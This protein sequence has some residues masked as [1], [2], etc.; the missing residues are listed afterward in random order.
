MGSRDN[1]AVPRLPR[2]WSCAACLPLLTALLGCGS[3][4]PLAPWRPPRRLIALA[5]SVTE[6]VYALGAEARLVGVC[7]Q[8]DFP[9]AATRLPRVGGYLVPSVEAVLAAE[10]DL[11]VVVPSPGNREAV[12]AIER[13]GVRVLVVQDR[14]LADLWVS[15]RAVAGALGLAAAG[16]QLVG[17]V[18]RRLEAVRARV[19]D[20]P[21]RRVLLVVGHSPLVVAG[22]GTL[23][24]ELMTVAGGVNV[25]ADAG[26]SW[27]QI[28][29]ELVVARGPEVIIDAAMGTEE[30]GR[31]LFAGLVTVPAVRAG[32]VITF[33]A[34]TLYR[35][36]P[37]VPEAAAALAAVIHPE[38]AS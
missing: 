33:R 23:Q 24:D 12:R 19:A 9:E 20:L 37:R 7:A 2:P 28:S 30:G 27:P 6:I 31:E 26:Q 15:M 17:D 5:P 35:A 14:T 4:A 38:A 25:A 16:E 21:R 29:L 11:V 1:G 36:G 3:T 22:G 34:D 10:P 13:A 8:C 32:R 18:A